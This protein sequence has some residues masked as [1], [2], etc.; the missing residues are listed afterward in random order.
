MK[1]LDGFHH[2]PILDDMKR[3]HILYVVENQVNGKYYV[4]IHTTDR[5]NDSYI[6]CG[7]R[8]NRN[9]AYKSTQIALERSPLFAAIV[10][11]GKMNFVRHDIAFFL[12]RKDLLRAE[13]RIVTKSFI[14]QKDTYNAIVGGGAPPVNYGT[15][16]GNYGKRWSIEKRQKL[17]SYFKE[18]RNTVGQNNKNAKST[19][20][21][22]TWTN[23]VILESHLKKIGEEFGWKYNTIQKMCT[24]RTVVAKRYIPFL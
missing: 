19:Y 7:I 2:S 14:Q 15:A 12:N 4:G 21:I 9:F 11:Y 6:G 22:D 23:K 24:Q 13:K 20:L 18:N 10:K 8:S 16:N 3:Y 5:L 17:S 1:K